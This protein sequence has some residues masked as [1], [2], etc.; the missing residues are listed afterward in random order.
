M[1][2]VNLLPGAEVV[3]LRR[4]EKTV[5]SMALLHLVIPAEDVDQPVD[6]AASLHSSK[7]QPPTRLA[8]GSVRASQ[9]ASSGR[10]DS[11]QAFSS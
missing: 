11:V 8:T 4:G 10:R 5:A 7:F 2:S 1:K 6:L 9:F 3:R